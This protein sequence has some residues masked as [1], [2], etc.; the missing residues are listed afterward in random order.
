MSSVGLI[1]ARRRCDFVPSCAWAL[2]DSAPNFR[3]E[4]G[5]VGARVARVRVVAGA[6]ACVCGGGGVLGVD[7][8]ISSR[9]RPG[10][11]SSGLPPFARFVPTRETR[12]SESGFFVL[13][14]TLAA[15]DLH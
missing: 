7:P 9:R 1:R 14:I 6:R 13:S 15:V 5:R 2:G 10:T 11:P 12:N 4:K 3:F 8:G